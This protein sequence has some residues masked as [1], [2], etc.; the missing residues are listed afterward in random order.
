MKVEFEFSEHRVL[1]AAACGLVGLFA[2]HAAYPGLFDYWPKTSSELADWVAAGG[3]IG[4]VAAGFAVANKQQRHQ[5]QLL[6]ETTREGERVN[7]VKSYRILAGVFSAAAALM[8]ASQK[9]LENPKGQRWEIIISLMLE[10]RDI[11]DIASDPRITDVNFCDQARIIRSAL[12]SLHTQIVD[13]EDRERYSKE[14]IE[15]LRQ[16][17]KICEIRALNIFR[18]ASNNVAKLA[19]HDELN[20]FVNSVRDSTKVMGEN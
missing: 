20:A 8:T 14:F 7:S 13:D 3:T 10:A 6:K 9:R 11:L 4:A 5:A 12:L 1:V 19:T 2:L 17:F 15:H 16:Q 18:L